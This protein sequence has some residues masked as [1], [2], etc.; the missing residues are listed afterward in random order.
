MSLQKLVELSHVYGQDK[1][2]VIAGGGN[3]SFKDASFLFIKGSG[4]SL[5]SIQASGFVKMNRRALAEIWSKTYPK[6]TDAREKQVLA[7]LMD[8]REPEERNK[9]PSVETLLHD[10]FPHAFVVHTHPPLVNGLTCSKNGEREMKKLFGTKACWIPTVNPGYILA[11]TVKKA[12]LEHKDKNGALPPYLFMQNHG[13]LVAADTDAIVKK[14][15]EDLFAQLKSALKRSPDFTPVER[16]TALAASVKQ[17][18][19]TLLRKGEEGGIC[20][21]ASNKE[22]DGFLKNETAFIPLSSAFSPD[23]IV[24][25]GYRPLFVPKT[26]DWHKALS[27]GLA[28]YRRRNSNDPKV[29]AF[30]GFGIFAYGNSQKSAEIVLDEYMD[31][32]KIAVYAESFGGYQFMPQDQI[33][34]IRNWEV[35]QYRAKVSAR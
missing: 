24:Y 28:D 19:E 10:F 1:E 4:T 35:E 8:A 21:F 16:D 32:V 2:F 31:A 12:L 18:I 13:V 26:N 25:C 5:A 30:E 9:R 3:T 29:I 7:D 22:L 27:A 15:Y 33:E 20:L 23:H 14:L 34:F 17:A 11:T 6:D